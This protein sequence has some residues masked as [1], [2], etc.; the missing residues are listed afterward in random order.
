[1][2]QSR[3]SFDRHC[4]PG[5]DGGCQSG[6]PL[7]F[8]GRLAFLV[9]R[10][11]DQDAHRPLLSGQTGDGG[12]VCFPR[13]VLQYGQWPGNGAARIADGYPQSLVARIDCQ[14]SHG[15]LTWACSTAIWMGSSGVAAT[16]WV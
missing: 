15:W 9:E 14:N 10:L 4:D 12:S 7:T 3:P 5:L 16:S 6:C 1:V 8:E 13:N 2:L 11:P